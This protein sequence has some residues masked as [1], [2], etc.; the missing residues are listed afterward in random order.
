MNTSTLDEMDLKILRCL[1]DDAKM[2]TREIAAKVNLS[3]TPVFERIRR[4][5]NEGYIKRYTAVLD[6][7]KMGR[8]LMVFCSVKLKQMNRDIAKDFVS[9][10][11]NIPEVSACY[12]VA[13]EFDYILTIYAPDMKY[14]NDFIINVLGTVES[15]GSILSTFVMK[16]IKQ[17]YGIYV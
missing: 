16:E 2:T 13:G 9:V 14:Y 12:N 3:T 17:G 10:I 5:E 4:L 8:G 1:Q 15:I 7:D 6:P 11:R